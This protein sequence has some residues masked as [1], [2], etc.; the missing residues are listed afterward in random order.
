M[1]LR[2]DDQQSELR[3]RLR[4][5]LRQ[6]VP[7]LP[8]APDHDDHQGRRAYDLDW[9]RR[10]FDAGFA[11]MDWPTEFGG[12]GGTAAEQLIFLEETGRAAAPG[13]GVNLVGLMHAGPTLIAMAPEEI[14]ARLVPPILRGES[15]WCQGFSEP[16][17]GSDLAAIN[18]R[19]ERDGDEYVISGQK[20][21]STNAHVADWCEMVVRTDPNSVGHNGLSWLAVPMDSPGIDVRPIHTIDGGA[22]FC[23]VFLDDVRCPVSNRVGEEGGGWQVAMTTL[24]QERLLAFTGDLVKATRLA[25]EL[26]ERVG[27]SSAEAAELAHLR[28]ELASAWALLRR[29]VSASAHGEAPRYEVSTFKLGFSTLA[30]RLGAFAAPIAIRALSGKDHRWAET[31]LR[32]RLWSFAFEIAGGTSQ[33]QR[34][35]IAERLLGLPRSAR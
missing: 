23:E 24:T 9:Q 3:T 11:G 20:V 2:D 21:W 29:N 26:V 30:N 12:Q 18:T 28:A 27:A 10:L 25:D 34:D 22:D 31:A 19:A 4:T 35:I 5:W 8:P 33:I 1:R 14:R 16:G 13:V 17:A 32:Q 7:Q 15:V 6:T